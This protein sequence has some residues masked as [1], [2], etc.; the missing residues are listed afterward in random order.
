MTDDKITKSY[1]KNFNNFTKYQFNNNLETM[2]DVLS[3]EVSSEEL[4]VS[5]YLFLNVVNDRTILNESSYWQKIKVF[6]NCCVNT[7][8]IN[9]IEEAK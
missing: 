9:Y 5:K 3:E 4:K 6:T 8:H 1:Y 7:I 2:T